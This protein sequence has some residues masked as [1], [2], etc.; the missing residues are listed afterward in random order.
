MSATV[1]LSLTE[2]R[3]ENFRRER[4]QTF[5]DEAGSLSGSLL[6]FVYAAWPHVVP[7]ACVPTWHIESICEHLEAAYRREIPRLIITIQPGALKSTL[8][9]VLAPAWRWTHEPCERIISA[10]HADHLA[11]RDTRKSREL[12][13][14]PWYQDRWGD[15][16]QLSLDEN[17]KTRYSNTVGGHRIATHVEGGTGERGGVLILDDP[18]N[19]REVASPT[20]LQAARD[21]VGDTWSS[22]LNVSVD[23]P[24]VKIVIGQRVHE[25]DVIGFLLDGGSDRWTHLCLP[26]RYDKRHPYLTPKRVKLASGGSVQGDVRTKD[27]ELLASAYMNEAALADATHDMTE[28]V[29]ASQYQQRPSPRE[30]N[31]LKRAQWGYYPVEMSPYTERGIFGAQVAGLP[32]FKMLVHSWD[33][34]LKDRKHSDFVA[35]QIWAADGAR[36]YLLRLFHQRAG[37]NKTVDVME[38]FYSWGVKHFPHV[39]QYVLIESAANGPDAIAEMKR[40]V[41]GVTPVAA[42]GTKGMRAESASPAL[43]GGNCFVP[44]YPSEDL[45]GYDARTPSDVQEFIE[46]CA[47]FRPEIDHQKDDQVDAWSQAVNWMRTRGTQRAVIAGVM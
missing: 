38:E 41:Q 35:G 13:Q 31:L 34:S 8:V 14:K 23:D 29:K 42:K 26:A 27:G 20:K 15:R 22:R 33:T 19:A 36:Y 45:Q 1:D 24:G 30:G 18:H 44:G 3:A 10:S 40:R 5:E 28:V 6:E 11:A 4:Q 39:P 12:I 32:A 47:R 17:L 46:E 25:S 21:W 7:A 2:L 9:S 16:F 37:L 43:E